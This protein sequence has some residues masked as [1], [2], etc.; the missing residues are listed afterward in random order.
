MKNRFYTLVTFFLTILVLSSC[1]SD[2]IFQEKLDVDP[3]GWLA[4]SKLEFGFEISD[5]L[6]LYDLKLDVFYDETAYKYE[7]LY[8]KVF[9]TFPDG[10]R[11]ED[12]IS[13]E[14]Q[15]SSALENTSCMSET[16]QLPVYLQQGIGFNQAGL[17][18]LSFEQY[19][20]V[21]TLLGIKKLQL[22]VIKDKS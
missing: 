18:K 13:F 12:M 8:V 17:Y 22:T 7:N 9:T 1:N 20:R 21:D 5:T 19:G 2:V 14:M 15:T 4:D 10:A 11:I 16:C 6:P 3:V